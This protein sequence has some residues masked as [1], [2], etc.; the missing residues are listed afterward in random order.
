VRSLDLAKLYPQHSAARSVYRIFLA[1][2]RFDNLPPRECNDEQQRLGGDRLE[3]S[4]NQQFSPSEVP[5]P[6]INPIQDPLLSKNLGRWAQVYFSA[7]PAQRDAAVRVLIRELQ[8]AAASTSSSSDESEGTICPV[9][10]SYNPADQRFCGFCG[11]PLKADEEHISSAEM[12][13]P[14]PSSAESSNNSNGNASSDLEHLRELSFATIYDDEEPKTNGWKYFA[15][16]LVVIAGLGLAIYLQW[17]P[18]VLAK[19]GVSSSVA[20]V[21]SNAPASP[22]S[23]VSS[24]ATQATAAGTSN[25][26]A[27]QAAQNPAANQNASAQGP[28]PSVTDIDSSGHPVPPDASVPAN[29]NVNPKDKLPAQTQAASSGS[30][31]NTRSVAKTSNSAVKTAAETG[32]VPPP[33]SANH[34]ASAARIP[35]PVD[36]GS[37]ELQVAEQYLDSGNGPRNPT[38]AAQWL[39]KAVAKKN[40]TALVLL[41]NLYLRGDGVPRSCEQARILLVTAAKQGAPDVAPQLRS[42]EQNG[43]K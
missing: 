34:P 1:L 32:Q 41:S 40:S 10:K 38:A 21:T 4:F 26:P 6:E 9:C 20:S 11:L 43:C 15:L 29:E 5:E 35:A 36:N 16:V 14:A 28:A 17:G 12:A 13:V 39:W 2:L 24:P 25:P 42:L 7:P 27:T 19:F 3:A 37:Q 30:P 18:Q 33:A 23:P 22:A 8:L 31:Q